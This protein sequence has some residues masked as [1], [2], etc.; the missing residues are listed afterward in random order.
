[1]KLKIKKFTHDFSS[2]ENKELAE[3]LNQLLGD[4][5]DAHTEVDLTKIQAMNLSKLGYDCDEHDKVKLIGVYR[6]LSKKSG[7]MDIIK[8]LLK[9]DKVDEDVTYGYKELSGNYSYGVIASDGHYTPD[10]KTGVK[11]ESE[12]MKDVADLLAKILHSI[13]PNSPHKVILYGAKKDDFNVSIS[14]HQIGKGTGSASVLLSLDTD[15]P[16]G[17]IM[18]KSTNNGIKPINVSYDLD[19]YMDALSDI[20]RKLLKKLL[21]K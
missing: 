8:R 17:S 6:S 12:F 11:M 9:L 13:R 14:V 10:G 19:H 5:E 16:I 7:I 15:N 18:V 20:L 4:P 3:S 1:M 21:S 2:W